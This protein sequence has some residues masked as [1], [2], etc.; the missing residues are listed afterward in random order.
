MAVERL[1]ESKSWKALQEKETGTIIFK[2]PITKDG[3]EKE[4]VLEEQIVQRLVQ[5]SNMLNS[6]DEAIDE[7]Q[8]YL[9]ALLHHYPEEAEMIRKAAD[10]AGKKYLSIVAEAKVRAFRTAILRGELPFKIKRI[11]GGDHGA[12]S[13]ADSNG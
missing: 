10:N 7:V 11:L 5:Y 3:S 1:P 8:R 12:D 6:Y 4:G 13:G 2:I 9:K